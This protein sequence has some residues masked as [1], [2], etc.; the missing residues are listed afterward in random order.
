MMKISKLK[1]QI[2]STDIILS[3]LEFGIFNFGISQEFEVKKNHH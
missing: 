3:R 1:S 2:P